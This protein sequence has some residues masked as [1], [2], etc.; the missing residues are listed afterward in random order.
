M[1]TED[2]LKLNRKILNHNK[3]KTIDTDGQ[4]VVPKFDV[5]VATVWFQQAGVELYNKRGVAA[6]ES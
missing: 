2:I 4:L 6:G 1:C 3:E 5:G